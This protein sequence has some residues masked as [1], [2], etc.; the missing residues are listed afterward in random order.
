MTN[1][2]WKR[3][4]KLS[5]HNVAIH[6]LWNKKKSRHHDTEIFFNELYFIYYLVIA[7]KYFVTLQNN[8]G[9]EISITTWLSLFTIVYDSSG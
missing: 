3:L 5:T 1:S 9:L 8:S 7:T 6:R 2:M 4:W